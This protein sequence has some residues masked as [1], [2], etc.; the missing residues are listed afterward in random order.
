MFEPKRKKVQTS[1]FRELDV[2][3]V[4]DP[5][6]TQLC[7]LQIVGQLEKSHSFLPKIGKSKPPSPP[8]P[9]ATPPPELVLPPTPLVSDPSAVVAAARKAK[10]EGPKPA[11]PEQTLDANLK[12]ET[13]QVPQTHS[14]LYGA[15]ASLQGRVIPFSNL[16]DD[17]GILRQAVGYLQ[18]DV[19][20][21]RGY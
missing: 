3:I 4:S 9:P 19:Y 15:L 14:F 10:G 16:E 17:R 18:H 5:L 20:R 2:I 1:K 8:P 21:N 12:P 11:G 6:L 7:A 13:E